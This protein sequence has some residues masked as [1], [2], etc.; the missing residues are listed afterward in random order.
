MEWM[1]RLFDCGDTR[2]RA[3]T[4]VPGGDE[5]PLTCYVPDASK[6]TGQRTNLLTGS[7]ESLQT[8]NT[9]EL[10]VLLVSADFHITQACQEGE[11]HPWL[12]EYKLEDT[13]AQI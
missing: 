4:T 9:L 13:Q 3:F 2:E 5:E 7:L 11:F 12:E 8:L 10:T 6:G 1:T